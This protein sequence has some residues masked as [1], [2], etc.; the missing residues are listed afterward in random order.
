[1]FL[2][3]SALEARNA[4]AS[5]DPN[6]SRA[7]TEGS[8]GGPLPWRKWSFFLT[9]Q[10]MAQR[11]VAVINA[12]TLDGPF[13]SDAPTSQRRSSLL[14][15]ADFRPNDGDALS[16]RY[17]L[18]GD[19]Q[20][21]LGVGGFG[22]REQGYTAD[23][24]RHRIQ[25]SDRRVAG[26]ALNDLRIEATESRT[27]AGRMPLAP[28]I[29][30]AGAFVAGPS[31]T[32]TA[33]RATAAQV[34]DVVTTT[35]AGHTARF[36]ARVRPR[37][38]TVTDATNFAGTYHFSSLADYAAGRPALFVR[39]TGIPDAAYFDADASGFAETTFRPASQVGITAGVRYDWQSRVADWNNLAPRVAAAYAPTEHNLV[40]RAGFGRFHQSIPQHV[41]ARTLLFGAGGVRE[42]A[43][44]APAFPIGRSD[45]GG[46]T[47]TWTLARDTAAPATTQ[48]SVSLERPLGKKAVVAAEYLHLRTTGALRARDVNAPLRGT[49]TRPD[50]ARLNVFEVDSIGTSRTD[51]LTVTF[52]ARAR[53][54][55]TNLQYTF[56]RTIDDGSGSLDLPADSFNRAAE[57]GRADFDR[58]HRLNATATYGWRDDRIRIGGVL[59]ASTGAPFDIQTGADDNHDLVVN[60]RPAGIARNSGAGPAFTQLD[61]R[62][63]TV[64]RAPRPP[65]ADPRSRKRERTDNL[66]MNIDVFNAFNATNAPTYVGVITSPLFGQAN[67]AGM[68]RTA[69]MSLRYRF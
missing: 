41:I 68:A 46:P 52:R 51:A 32:F 9:G 49:R 24:H 19:V 35:V 38:A 5:T 21:N 40:L 28:A 22:L 23:E 65:S 16:I 33:E 8:V 53:A 64:F 20:R 45:A 55:R 7:L 18:E 26:T 34:Q 30:V 29:A 43:L 39:R 60:D 25:V 56:G 31:Q 67:A 61:L 14:G 66:E 4:F 3:N 36:G 59:V 69:Q 6:M 2:R 1:M 42:E 48:T 62:M 17:D 50:P 63:T 57:R 13:V 11:D 15:K 37:W 58:R 54:L 47:A 27:G 10:R 12:R 44:S